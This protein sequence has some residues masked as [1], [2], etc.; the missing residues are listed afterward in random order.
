M[1]PFVIKI[2]VLSI[3][4]S[5]S[6]QQQQKKSLFLTHCK[7]QVLTVLTLPILKCVYQI[8]D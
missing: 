4:S 2:F 8:F 7:A 6:V 5:R 3:L 1:L